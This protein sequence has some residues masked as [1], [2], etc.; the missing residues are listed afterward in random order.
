MVEQLSLS[1]EDL[2]SENLTSISPFFI[3]VKFIDKP[4]A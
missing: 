3:L 1:E 4:N 2:L